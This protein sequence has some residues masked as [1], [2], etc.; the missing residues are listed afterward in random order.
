MTI[1]DVMDALVDAGFKAEEVLEMR[2][3]DA[4]ALLELKLDLSSQD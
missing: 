2:L 3:P 1:S 4:V